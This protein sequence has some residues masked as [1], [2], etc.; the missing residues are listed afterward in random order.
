MDE[1]HWMKFTNAR[2]LSPLVTY[3]YPNYCLLSSCSSFS[4]YFITYI[5]TGTSVLWFCP[6]ACF[7][8]FPMARHPYCVL[9]FI[10]FGLPPLGPSFIYVC[11]IK[12]LIKVFVCFVFLCI[13]ICTPG[14]EAYF[15]WH[16]F[17]KTTD[18]GLMYLNC[19]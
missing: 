13:E 14:W 1:N 10:I 3:K 9:F 17:L 12:H 6:F 16:F 8:H 7:Y 19:F 15:Q 5:L 2:H 4:S 11:H 18:F